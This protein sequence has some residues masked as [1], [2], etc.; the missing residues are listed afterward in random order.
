MNIIN[1]TIVVAEEKK[2]I[3]KILDLMSQAI[4]NY[5]TRMNSTNIFDAILETVFLVLIFMVILFIIFQCFAALL[6]S[7]INVFKIIGNFLIVALKWGAAFFGILLFLW[8]FVNPNRQC[9]FKIEDSITHCVYVE[10]SKPKS[11]ANTPKK[12]GKSKTQK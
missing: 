11:P 2:G 7:A 8:F 10:K 3:A 5:A 4:Q 6:Q 1:I 9:L 12:A